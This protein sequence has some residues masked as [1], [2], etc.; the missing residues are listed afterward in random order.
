MITRLKK[1]KKHLAQKGID[2]FFVS[3]TYDISYLTNFLSFKTES[4][5]AYLLITA[6]K[7]FIFTSSL[8]SEAVEIQVKD[9]ELIEFGKG[10][11][12]D[13][14]LDLAKS[15]KIHKLG[16]SEDD[17][18]VTEHK[19]LKR[20]FK[21]IVN[22]QTTDARIIK[23]LTEIKSIEK[24]CDLG[25]QTFKFILKKLKL[26]VT[27]KEIAFEMEMFIKKMGATLSFDTIV[28]FQAN[29]SVPHHQTGNTKLEKNNIVLLDFGT[30]FNNYCS[31]MT[32]TVFFGKASQ[33]QKEI[34]ETV[35]KAQQ[36]AVKF[37]KQKIKNKKP[38]KAAAVDKV[39]RDYIESKGYSF[40]HSLG[41]GVG[42]EIH[43][44]PWVSKG[45]KD[46]LKVGMV[47]S[48][49]PGIYLPGFGG[50]RIEDLYVLEPSGLRQLTKSPKDRVEEF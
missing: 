40:A 3:S 11:F 6:S 16:V 30:K 42:H 10:N 18:K 8:Y 41:H 33:K 15:E 49:E 24:A 36:K 23:E 45:S 9:F 4:R 34:Y 32:R 25:D 21:K 29:S 39:A 28:A 1:I 14:L 37:I 38:I 35:L 5:D 13:K 50:V 43:E 31:D 12:K 26:G 19:F 7:Q 46:I 48:I 47:F 2:A 17:L 20:I 22:F 27:E 44:R